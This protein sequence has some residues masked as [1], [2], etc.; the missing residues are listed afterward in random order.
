[1]IRIEGINMEGVARGRYEAAHPGG[2]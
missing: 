1:L 2:T